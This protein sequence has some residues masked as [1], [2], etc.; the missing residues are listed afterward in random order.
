MEDL[1]KSR[2]KRKWPRNSE[3]EDKMHLFLGDQKLTKVR[4]RSKSQ[5]DASNIES[6]ESIPLGILLDCYFF[7]SFYSLSFFSFYSLSLNTT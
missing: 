7:Y 6:A 1:T 4:S 2:K 3:S 5:S